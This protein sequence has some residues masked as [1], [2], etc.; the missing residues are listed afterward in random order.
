MVPEHTWGLD[1]K[2]YTSDRESYGVTGL[3]QGEADPRFRDARDLVA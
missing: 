2:E 3:R 1:E